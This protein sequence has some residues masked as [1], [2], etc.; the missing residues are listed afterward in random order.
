MF[1]WEETGSQWPKYVIIRWVLMIKSLHLCLL[2]G[3]Y[4]S[5]LTFLVK[6]FLK[7]NMKIK[8]PMKIKYFKSIKKLTLRAWMWKQWQVRYE[9]NGRNCTAACCFCSTSDHKLQFSYINKN[10]NLHQ[11]TKLWHTIW[12]KMN[13]KDNCISSLCEMWCCCCHQEIACFYFYITS[14][15]N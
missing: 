15:H 13:T 4:Y 8:Q 5:K 12:L 9:Y 2:S 6:H 14:F 10:T 1:C 11:S 3:G 7:S